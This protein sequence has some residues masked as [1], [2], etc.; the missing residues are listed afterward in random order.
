MKSKDG[1]DYK[2]INYLDTYKNNQNFT[3]LQSLALIAA[4]LA[5][6]NKETL[7]LKLFTRNQ[8]KVKKQRTLGTDSKSQAQG[9]LLIGKTKKFTSERL[10]SILD[11]IFAIEAENS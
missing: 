5:G 1:F 9:E 10:L 11:F 3:F 2:R 7:D 4:Y 8:T 6:S